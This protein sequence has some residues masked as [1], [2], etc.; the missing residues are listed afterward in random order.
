MTVLDSS[1]CEL[2]SIWCLIIVVG[3][4]TEPSS[5]TYMFTPADGAASSKIIGFDMDGT[6]IV[7]K[8][9]AKWPKDKG[10]F[11]NN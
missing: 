3:E 6:L 8:S 9:G 10:T 7:T 1:S 11:L 4:W 2:H 5:L